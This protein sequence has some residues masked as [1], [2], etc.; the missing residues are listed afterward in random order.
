MGEEPPSKRIPCP[1]LN[2]NLVEEWTLWDSLNC[3]WFAISFSPSQY[4][5]WWEILNGCSPATPTGMCFVHFWCSVLCKPAHTF[6]G[7][8]HLETCLFFSLKKT[9]V[10]MLE[11][12][13]IWR[14]RSS[15]R[16][17]LLLEWTAYQNIQIHSLCSLVYIC[18]WRIPG[19]WGILHGNYTWL[20]SPYIH[21]YLWEDICG[22]KRSQR[23]KTTIHSKHPGSSWWK[24]NPAPV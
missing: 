6:K 13:S 12:L 9:N 16:I 10:D 5:Q 14:K 21:L 8:I 2:I 11:I 4:S 15:K 23:L 19:N 7:K 22:G 3:C 20:C 18:T 1:G 17:T 24:K